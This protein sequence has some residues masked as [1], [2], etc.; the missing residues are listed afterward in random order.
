MLKTQ[1]LSAQINVNNLYP[2]WHR[3][4]ALLMCFPN[5]KHWYNYS[6]AKL[7]SDYIHF[8]QI[9]LNFQ[10]VWLLVENIKYVRTY[11]TD[12]FSAKYQLHL[13]E[14]STDDCW[15]RDYGALQVG[16]KLINAKFNGWG[17]KFSFDLDNSVNA[18]LYDLGLIRNM[19]DIDFVFE[20]GALESDGQGTLLITN[21]CVFNKNRNTSKS[22]VLKALKKYYFAK[23]ILCID[24]SILSGDDTD[25]HIDLLARFINPHTIAYAKAD[26]FHPDFISLNAME[27]ELYKFRDIN[28]KAY[29]LV[30]VPMPKPIFDINDCMLPATYLNFILINGAL[31]VPSYNQDLMDK[32]AL[33]IL[34]IAYPNRQVISVPSIAFIHQGGALHCLCTEIF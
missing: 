9:V 22:L 24:N 14:L 1:G 18:K 31:L 2:A 30:P 21:Q 8:L 34:S 23:H 3:Q 5:V 19:L 26:K 7:I 13:I 25:G 28:D 16:S 29:N 12:C 17:N 4:R 27:K 33:K 15:V 6:S 10:P 11:L 20:G 32:K